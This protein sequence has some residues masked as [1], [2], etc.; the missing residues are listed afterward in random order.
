MQIITLGNERY[1]L[2]IIDDYSRYTHIYLLNHKTEAVKCIKA[3]MEII[4]TQLKKKTEDTLRWKEYINE[5]LRE[6]LRKEQKNRFLLEMTRCMLLDA[7]LEKK[8]RR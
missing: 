2:T 3:F 7:D 4:R 1:I 6:Y 8:E 5:D